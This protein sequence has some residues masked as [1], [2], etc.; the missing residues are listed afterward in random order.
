MQSLNEEIKK[1]RDTR[2]WVT[3]KVRMNAEEQMNKNSS[4]NNFILNYYTF[5]L[6]SLSIILLTFSNSGLEL[7]ILV[8]SIALFG[9]S[10]YAST[11][12]FRG[13]ALQYKDSYIQLG[14]IENKLDHLLLNASLSY[15]DKEQ[16]F[17]H[18][19]NCYIAE[20]AKN[21]NQSKEDFILFNESK[22]RLNKRDL[23]YFVI[24][25]KTN[26]FKVSLLMIP[27]ISYFI[28]YLMER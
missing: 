25:L 10:I 3:K 4:F 8:A 23:N 12:N 17:L 11:A 19:K 7:F 2:V 18:I 26:F 15:E 1:Y 14:Y 9:Y 20:M 21:E 13:K 24:I 5:W 6:L 28:F 22:K 27:P 16:Q